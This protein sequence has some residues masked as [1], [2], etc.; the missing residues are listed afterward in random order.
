MPP[1]IFAQFQ[2]GGCNVNRAS[3]H[4]PKLTFS[5]P[6]PP[7][8]ATFIPSIT[9]TMA[10]GGEG[11][12]QPKDAVSAAVKGSFITGGAGLLMSATQNALQKRRVGAWAIFSR[13]GGNVAIFSMHQ[14]L[15]G[16]ARVEVNWWFFGSLTSGD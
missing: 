5:S 15:P 9:C 7:S 16:D 4:I 8:A 2:S 14:S 3:N 10:S 11:H 6:H 13:T 12:Y 1:I